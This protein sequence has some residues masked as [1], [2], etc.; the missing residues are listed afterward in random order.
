V[1]AAPGE[2]G[3]GEEPRRLWFARK[4]TG[5]GFGPVEWRG[6]AVTYLY[7]LLVVAAVFT[8]SRLALTALVVVF[9]TVVYGCLVILKSDVL[10]DWPPGR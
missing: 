10:K 9:Y 2:V 6:R 7:V 5:L 1:P 3:P 4:T 8:Y